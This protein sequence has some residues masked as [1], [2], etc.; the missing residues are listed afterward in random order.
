[1]NSLDPHESLSMVSINPDCPK[2]LVYSVRRIKRMVKYK[3]LNLETDL[4]VIVNYFLADANSKYHPNSEIGYS[5]S[6]EAVEKRVRL[7]REWIWNKEII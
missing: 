1:M 2:D 4:E 5:W 6:K 7:A 3:N